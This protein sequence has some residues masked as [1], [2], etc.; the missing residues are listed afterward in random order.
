M[1]KV[2]ITKEDLTK[3]LLKRQQ[4]S[5]PIL[6]SFCWIWIFLSALMLLPILALAFTMLLLYLP[7][8]FVDEIIKR[9]RNGTEL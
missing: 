3:N 9:R 4:S 1:D 7:F 2:V 8:Y 5:G 6:L